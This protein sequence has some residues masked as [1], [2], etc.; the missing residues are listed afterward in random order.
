MIMKSLI[1][2]VAALA[3]SATIAQAGLVT[4]TA[5]VSFFSHTLVEDIRADNYSV[6]SVL[7]EET[8]EIVFSVP[9]QAF[10]FPK[11]LMQKHFNSGM[12]MNTKKLN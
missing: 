10:E 7:N 11:A 8:G 5:S 4:K 6:S 1:S 3:A 12:F 2:I 9:M